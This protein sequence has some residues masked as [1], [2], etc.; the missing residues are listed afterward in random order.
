[1]DVRI[2]GPL[3][4]WVDGRRVELRGGRQRALLA[5]L[6]LNRNSV[7]SSD[8][9]VDEL[10]G[11]Q[12][13]PTAAKML[14]NL[15]VQLRKALGEHGA[16]ATHAPG[17]A[18]RLGDDQV[19]AGRFERLAAEGRRLLEED[20][21]TAADRLGAALALWR[22]EALAEFAYEPFG[23][24]ESDRLDELRLAALED[25]IEADLRLEVRTDLVP[26]LEA[27]V[28]AH[29]LRERLR[30]QLMLALYRTG[31]QSA[32]LDVYREGR[33]L[34]QDELGLEPGPALRQLQNAILTHDPALGRPGKL[35][36]P[37][38]ARRRRLAV[39][40]LAA[41]L[42]AAA[43]VA[44]A[45]VATR[46]DSAPS[47]VANSLV[48]I[49]ARTNRVVDVVPVGHD[50]GQ[51]AVVGDYVFVAGQDDGTL[52]RV[53]RG[54]GETATSGRYDP[55]GSIAGAGDKAL[56]VV[57]AARDRVSWL[58][59][60][61]LE[62]IDGVPLPRTD[63]LLQSWVE[64]GGDSV[65][66]SQWFPPAVTRWRLRTL[67]R[68]RTYPLLEAEY[69]LEVTF[70]HGAAWVALWATNRVLRI[71]AVTGRPSYIRVGNGPRDPV[72]A[73]GS[74]WVAMGEDGTVWRIHPRSRKVEAV[75]EV[76]RLPW[77][78]AV[79]DDAVWVTNNCD[80]TVSRI[81]PQSNEIVAT[82]DTGFFPQWVAATR[83]HLWV[84]LAETWSPVPGSG[85]STLE[86]CD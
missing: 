16:I 81:D 3:E 52:T 56:W 80:G 20:P 42:V 70:G 25:R 36:R 85:P 63:T 6:V 83:G 38:P 22:G 54:S 27:L 64:V 14:Q 8:R 29:P 77:G 17:Y 40:G 86:G 55:T 10:W 4:V 26:E 78:L 19:D 59:A 72:L 53:H 58:D 62:G 60:E 69:P 11:E 68:V 73:F 46:G 33:D 21:R 47:V 23:R 35:M 34:L 43:A 5:L 50:P 76:G 41:A 32:A 44:T 49:D 37:R 79:G 1:V 82:I 67:E 75:I 15:V 65:W 7:V 71:D 57:S 28:A 66:V 31:R 84:G 30:G 13:P 61:S 74:V 48:K 12:P 9:L 51:L 39:L 18:L 2:L 24:A 45:A